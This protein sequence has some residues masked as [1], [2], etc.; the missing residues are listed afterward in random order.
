[1]IP[2]T[3]EYKKNILIKF[4]IIKIMN[5]DID[6]MS[7]NK[8]KLNLINDDFNKLEM[9]LVSYYISDVDNYYK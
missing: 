6:I 7:F 2:L 8:D 4:I 1:M 9:G 3:T 5:H